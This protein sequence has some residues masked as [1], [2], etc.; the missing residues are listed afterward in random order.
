MQGRRIQTTG[1]GTSARRY[2]KVVGSCKSGNTVKQNDNIFFM[3]NKTFCTLNQH[4]GHS[5]MV[6]REFIEGRIDDF[7]IFP[8]DCFLN[9]GYFFR[10][11]IDQKNKQ[12]HLRVVSQ[13]GESHFF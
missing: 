11:F 10:T 1:K 2:N 7:H 3:L 9:I 12:M 13:N 6:I 8:A 4:F 5:L